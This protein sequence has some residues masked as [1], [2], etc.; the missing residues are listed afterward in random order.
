MLLAVHDPPA[1]LVGWL[2]ALA[3]EA[4]KA[5]AGAARTTPPASGDGRP[6]R[7]N[8]LHSR[9]AQQHMRACSSFLLLIL[10]LITGW[11]QQLQGPSSHLSSNPSTNL[12]PDE[13]CRLISIWKTTAI[14]KTY[15]H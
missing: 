9:A 11:K 13:L 8:Y 7:A 10:L 2:A 15:K 1:R 3:G 6:R 4:R 5:V 14:K 12:L